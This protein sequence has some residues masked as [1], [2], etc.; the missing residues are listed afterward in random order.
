MNNQCYEIS[1]ESA[2]TQQLTTL[3]DQTMIETPTMTFK[4]TGDTITTTIPGV[5]V[6]AKSIGEFTQTEILERMVPVYTGS[7]TTSDTTSLTTPLLSL[8]VMN[9]LVSASKNSGILSQFTYFRAD[10]E[11]TLR[12]NTN[13]FYYGALM[14]AL[15]TGTGTPIGIRIEQR[16]VL[17]P[18]ILSASLETSVVQNWTY[19]YPDAWLLTSSPKGVTLLLDVLAPLMQGNADQP[20]SITYSIWA[21]FKNVRLAYPTGPTAYNSKP[22][23]GKSFSGPAHKG[24]PNASSAPTINLNYSGPPPPKVTVKK[25][26]PIKPGKLDS[27]AYVDHRDS[28]ERAIDAV[29][30]ITIADFGR[31]AISLGKFAMDNWSYIAEA[32]AAMA[33]FL[34]KPDRSV[35]QKAVIHEPWTDMYSADMADSNVVM[36]PY[37]DRYLTPCPSR[38]P[39]SKNFSYLD[40]AMIPGLRTLAYSLTADSNVYFNLIDSAAS[41]ATSILIPLDYA[42]L[43]SC[44][45]RGSIK[46]C[47]MFFTSSFISTRVAISVGP[48]LTDYSNGVSRIVDIKGDTLDCFT[49]PFISNKFW[50]IGSTINTQVNVT[51]IADIA[52]TDTTTDPIVYMLPWVSAG[53][54]MQFCLPRT[55][56]ATEWT[57]PASEGSPPPTRRSKAKISNHKSKPQCSVSGMFA[58]QFEP[59][60]EDS[61][62]ETDNGYC[63]TDLL[64]SITDL[65]KVYTPWYNSSVTFMPAYLDDYGAY[66]AEYW[67]FRATFFGSWRAAFNYRSGGYKYRFW[68]Y[69]DGPQAWYLNDTGFL[70]IGNSFVYINSPNEFARVTIPQVSQ[71]PFSALGDNHQ[72]TYLAVD[73]SLDSTVEAPAFVAARDD[74]QLGYPILPIRHQLTS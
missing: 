72:Q 48:L 5:S 42:L 30:S 25:K 21:R 55:L 51:V 13:Q 8:N 11:T 37:C 17:D 70:D 10:I 43:N 39:L 32:G 7:W 50:E 52:S 34:D 1:Q 69:D 57:L 31:G 36:A 64:S 59:I 41:S 18:T 66:G 73:A 49:V 2:A 27:N 60:I 24:S 29:S 26:K 65:C 35:I 3:T 61:F 9:S 54:D 68:G 16:A 53:P 20:D 6:H 38:L 19:N 62:Y 4:E 22:Q 33:F 44:L 28:M 71:Y 14:S 56:A 58:G 63:N 40:Y 47:L 12:L 46:V 67:S 45:W 15:C 74:I 23:S